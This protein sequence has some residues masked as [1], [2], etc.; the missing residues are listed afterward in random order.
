MRE[1]HPPPSARLCGLSR[2][3]PSLYRTLNRHDLGSKGPSPGRT[4]RS[5]QRPPS[6]RHGNRLPM[7]FR[8]RFRPSRAT[9]LG[10]PRRDGRFISRRHGSPLVTV[11]N[12]VRRRL[13]WTL[14]PMR[15]TLGYRPSRTSPHGGFKTR[16]FY[17]RTSSG[18]AIVETPAKSQYDG[19]AR[20][21]VY[22]KR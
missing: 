20:G 10:F 6:E 8:L 1:H 18:N 2:W 14:Q 21:S 11:Q 9:R 22:D 19:T 3:T 15:P 12:G 13:P 17:D 7:A 5:P 4:L 16:R